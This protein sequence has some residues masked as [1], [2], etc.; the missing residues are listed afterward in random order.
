MGQKIRPN[1]L[2]L[3]VTQ[4]WNACWMTKKNNFSNLLEEDV[5]IRK[6]IDSKIKNAGIDKVRIERIGNNYQI[7]IR[8]ARPGLIIGRGGKGVEELIDLLKT[9]IQKLRAEQHVKEMPNVSLNIEELKRGEVSSAIVGQNIAL[10]LEK[11]MPF[12]RTLKKYVEQ[13]AQNREVKGIK[14]KVSGR[15]DGNEISRR[16]QLTRGKL[17]LQTLRANIDYGEATAFCTY[18]AIGIKVWIYKGEIFDK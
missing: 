17:P 2:R 5:L 9:K 18:G 6:I 13:V 1:S 4:D 12:R 16:E 7:S 15:L 14:I 11:R 8:A 10:D 3:G